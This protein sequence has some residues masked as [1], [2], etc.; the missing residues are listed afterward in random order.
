[1]RFLSEI[2]YLACLGL[3]MLASSDISCSG[4]ERTVAQEYSVAKLKKPITIDGNWN[5]PV[6]KKI[7]SM[8]LGFIMGKE[9]AF[10]PTVNVKMAYDDKNLYLI[11]RVRDKFVRCVNNKFNGPVWDDSCVE[12]FFSPDTQYQ[13]K[14]FNL[15]INCGGTPLMYY[16]IIPRKNHV[17]LD[18]IDL[19]QIEIAHSLPE[20]VDPEIKGPTTWTVEYRI[21]T[22]LLKK[23]AEITKPDS[24]VVW[25][26]NFYKIGD[27]TSN[28]HYM[29]WS[30]IDKAE[31]D[32][33]QPAYFGIL[34]FK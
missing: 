2:R 25:K 14:Y 5:K 12:F 31:P 9:P 33:H 11:F 16:N 13:E 22:E 15:E 29:T 6:W 17:I 27:K 26:A 4:N 30:Y 20:I 19:R 32:F 28:P 23:Y 7:K 10:R 1:M 3:T 18:P 34:V 8:R 21:P 24:G